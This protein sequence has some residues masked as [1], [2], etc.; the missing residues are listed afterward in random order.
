M[1]ANSNHLLHCGQGRDPARVL[2]LNAWFDKMPAAEWKATLV[3][4]A[5]SDPEADRLRL[6]T[7]KINGDIH[8]RYKSRGKAGGLP[9]LRL[10]IL[11]AMR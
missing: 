2:D 1:H 4:I 10:R 6:H 3:T 11:G 9:F 8:D 7:R 5:D